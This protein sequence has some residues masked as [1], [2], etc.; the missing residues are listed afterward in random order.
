V[1]IALHTKIMKIKKGDS[2]K[3]ISGKDRGKTGIVLRAVP[4]TDKILVEG[5]NVFK[6][7]ARPKKQGETGQIVMVS[8][9][10]PASKV[11]VIC[12]N[13]KNAVRVGY[14]IEQ[15]AKIRYCKKCQSNT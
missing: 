5:L 9:P 3:I 10:L 7:R 11:M 8:R 1:Q 4:E 2:V 14:R 13:C 15:G 6:K 12:G